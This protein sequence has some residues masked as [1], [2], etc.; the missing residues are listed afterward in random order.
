[1][2]VENL[3]SHSRRNNHNS[4]L[5]LSKYY[6]RPSWVSDGYD[7]SDLESSADISTIHVVHANQ[8]VNLSQL[9]ENSSLPIDLHQHKCV[10]LREQSIAHKLEEEEH[11]RN[12]DGV[13]FE[14]EQRP[15]NCNQH[16]HDNG[17]AEQQEGI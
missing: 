1:M 15:E 17:N 6:S 12:E 8:H 10:H 4:W 5:V 13:E 16:T 14:Q 9:T 7:S 2:L 3:D 11:G